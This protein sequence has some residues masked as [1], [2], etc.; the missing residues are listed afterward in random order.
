MGC[1]SDERIIAAILNNGTLQEAAEALGMSR[2]A[3][4]NR[5]LTKD[6][7]ELYAAAKAELLRKTMLAAHQRSEK[8]MDTIEQIMND[9]GNPAGIRLQAARAILDNAAR[10]SDRLND[11]ETVKDEWF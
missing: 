4:Y 3:L 1:I 9:S 11:A 10:F 6:F 2:K 7:R 8:A 5:T